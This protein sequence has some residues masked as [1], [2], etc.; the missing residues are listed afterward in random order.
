MSNGHNLLCTEY[1]ENKKAKKMGNLYQT[2]FAK[3]V[4]QTRDSSPSPS[5]GSA[6]R[7]R[8]LAKCF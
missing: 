1:K 6:K 7:E 2:K 4:L 3:T 5:T 8:M